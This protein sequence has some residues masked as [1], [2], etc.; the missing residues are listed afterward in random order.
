[1]ARIVEGVEGREARL[2][3]RLGQNAQR[4]LGIF[5]ASHEGGRIVPIDKGA[6]REWRVARDATLGAQDGELVEAEQQGQNA[7]A[8]RRHGWWGGWAI[9]RARARSV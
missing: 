1:M 2:I 6:D 5:R 3:R 9:P 4:V 7:S 8:C